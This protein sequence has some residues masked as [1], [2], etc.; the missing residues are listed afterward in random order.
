MKCVLCP[1]FFLLFS[2]YVFLFP[3]L[4]YLFLFTFPI[5]QSP[6]N[7][8]QVQATHPLLDEPEDQCASYVVFGS[9][10]SY[11]ARTL[12]TA[13]T[14][15]SLAAAHPLLSGSPSHSLSQ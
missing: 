14:N 11:R 15:T 7:L 5:L 2:F 10:I 13:P 6:G 8:F 3:V 4:L 9:D 1:Y 12:E